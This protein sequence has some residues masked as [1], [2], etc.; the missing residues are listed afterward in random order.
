MRLAA[1]V[2][3]LVVLALASACNEGDPSGWETFVPE[4][5]DGTDEST[6][7]DEST[8]SESD[9]DTTTGDPEPAEGLR[10]LV[11]TTD[12][13]TLVGIDLD[14]PLAVPPA[15]VLISGE[16]T[17]GLFGSTPFESQI[18]TH[19]GV[20]DQLRISDNGDYDFLP[21]AEAE[22]GWMD[23]VFFDPEGANAIMAIGP[24]AFGVTNQLLWLEYD[25][26]GEVTWSGDITPPIEANGAVQVLGR[27]PDSKWA[28]IL[29]DVEMDSVWQL[30][31]LYMDPTPM[32]AT[33]IDQMDFTGLPPTTV[34]DF[35]WLHLDDQRIVYRKEGEPNV[36]RPLAVDLAVTP[37]DRIELTPSLGHI[38]SL[39]WSPDNTR[40]LVSAGGSSGYRDLYLI[41]LDGPTSASTPLRITE[42]GYPAQV[43]T[44]AGIDFT[45]L[46]H[47][48]DDY[49]RVWYAYTDPMQGGTANVGIALVVVVDGEL[50]S[51]DDLTPKAA[52]LEI[53]DVI[54][55]P[56]YQRL[57]YRAQMPGS[58]S[59][60][61]VDL[62]EPF[63]SS[64]KINQDFEHSVDVPDDDAKFAWGADGRLIVIAGVQD[65]LSVLHVADPTDL[66]GETMEITLPDVEAAQGIVL[67]H[68]PHVSPDSS[69]V[70][71]W[72]A[73]QDGRTG[74]VHA[75]TDGSA[76][77]Q[78]VLGLQYPLR[79]GTWLQRTAE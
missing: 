41:E 32:M 63:A 29:V 28:A 16:G 69:Q 38:N 61:T 7:D 9:D 56:K 12:D 10:Y 46:G 65:G 26:N 53:A 15:E 60:Y 70:I 62:T 27:S 51:R 55:D 73:V 30:Y 4:T 67:D 23:E 2:S 13:A 58:S 39:V 34:S 22:A 71:L 52:G 35:V 76:E 14:N 45:T 25:E 42:V 24:E 47:G 40:V 50:I 3:I 77:G 59:I 79:E 57:G 78:S 8:E 31:A 5:D 1:S 54:F 36:F 20:V 64:V 49:N 17:T 19:D 11:T 44:S 33:Y 74:L 43:D 21:L 48:F 72:Y 6:S 66:N 18:V 75:P 68:T 37:V